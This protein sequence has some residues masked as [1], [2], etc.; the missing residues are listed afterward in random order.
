[1]KLNGRKQPPTASAASALGRI[2]ADIEEAEERHSALAGQLPGASADLAA[3]RIDAGE[4]ERRRWQLLSDLNAEKDTL[5]ELY[6]RRVR[7]EG[8]CQ[9][10]RSGNSSLS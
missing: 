7:A 6:Q 8:N 9:P 10:R 4:W 5:D 2:D 1:M 3:G